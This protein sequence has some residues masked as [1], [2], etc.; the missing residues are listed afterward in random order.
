[1]SVVAAVTRYSIGPD[2]T[3]IDIVA[4]AGE[5]FELRIPILDDNDDPVAIPEGTEGLWTAWAQVR[6]NHYATTVLHEW[7][8][9]AA[10]PNAVIEPGDAAAVLLVATAQETSAWQDWPDYTCAWDLHLTEP[11]SGSGVPDTSRLADGDFRLRPR[12]TR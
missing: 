3:R 4:N 12:I 8:T 9:D 2:T 6:R 1:M 10:T 7:S 5:P 11:A